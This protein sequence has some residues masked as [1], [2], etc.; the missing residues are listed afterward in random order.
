MFEPKFTV[1]VDTASIKLLGDGEIRNTH[2]NLCIDHH[3][4]NNFYADETFLPDCAAAGEAVLEVLNELS[5]V[6]TPTMATALLT[7]L[8]SDTGSFKYSNTTAQTLQYGADLLR[9]GADKDLVRV[10]LYESKS[11][12]QVLVESAALAGCEFFSQDRLAVVT[13]PLALLEKFGADES[14]LEGL[15]AKPIE[16][17]GVDIAITIKER[18]DGSVRVSVRTSEKANACAICE[19]FEGG[20]HLRAA[21]CRLYGT[22]E[23]CKQKLIAEASKQL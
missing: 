9:A 20:G 1:T 13:V 16:I 11:R 23:E 4:S 7:A 5:C 18:A 19:V 21:G 6:I 22:V 12:A 14:E 15:A 2:V 17:N 10:N 3:P 8:S